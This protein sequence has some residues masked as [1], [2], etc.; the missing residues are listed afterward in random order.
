M[1]TVSDLVKCPQCGY[2][3]ADY[4]FNC[5]TRGEE[6]LCNRCGYRE[7][8][9]AKRDEAG[10]F[11]GWKH[12]IS[13]GAGALWYHS[14]EGIAYACHSLHSANELAEAERWLKQQLEAGTV[15]QHTA[16]LTRWNS[17]AHTVELVLGTLDYAGTMEQVVAEL[18]LDPL[19]CSPGKVARFAMLPGKAAVIGNSSCVIVPVL[20]YLNADS[21]TG[22]YELKADGSMVAIESEI[23]YIALSYPELNEIN[24]L[25]EPERSLYDIDVVMSVSSSDFGRDFRRVCRRARWTLDPATEKQ[26]KAI[27][28]DA[29]SELATKCVGRPGVELFRDLRSAKQNIDLSKAAK[30]SARDQGVAGDV[31]DDTTES[32]HQEAL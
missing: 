22:R 19:T 11:L 1:S 4:E 7:S 10:D 25:Q 28:V 16:R 9:D 29:S 30:S 5:R 24:K 12:D 14:T 6:T 18:G 20:R 17:E 31:T 26:V 8:W 13:Q 23:E 2:E 15:D 21:A 32:V 27:I 3:E